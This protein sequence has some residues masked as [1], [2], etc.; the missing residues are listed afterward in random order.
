M[1]SNEGRLITAAL[2]KDK[3]ITVKQRR[4]MVRILVAFLIETFGEV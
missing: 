4:A 2:E 3:S 1:A